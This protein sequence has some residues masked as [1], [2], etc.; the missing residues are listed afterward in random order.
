MG[1]VVRYKRRILLRE[2]KLVAEYEGKE[3]DLIE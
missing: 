3:Y 2:M 1:V